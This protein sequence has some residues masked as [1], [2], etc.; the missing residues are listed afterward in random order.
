M[1][2]EHLGGVEDVHLLVLLQLLVVGELCQLRVSGHP[3]RPV[4]PVFTCDRWVAVARG[5]HEL[6]LWVRNRG[7]RDLEIGVARQDE[8]VHLCLHQVAR[9]LHGRVRP[10][11]D[12]SELQDDLDLAADSAVLVD[13]L[14][15]EL[16][17]VR[18]E[19]VVRCEESGQVVAIADADRAFLQRSRL[20]AC[21]TETGGGEDD[22]RE[23]R[24]RDRSPRDPSPA[25][26]TLPFALTSRSFSPMYAATTAGS[27]RTSSGV[28]WLI[29]SPWLRT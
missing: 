12:V 21:A 28:P 15:R 16:R 2:V 10:A 5:E 18:D 8:D 11:L 23:Q 26:S 22:E 17:T 29:T 3:D 24:R 4:V 20:R 27:E 13:L 9:D 14:D 25:H 1:H 19:D 6:A 7:H